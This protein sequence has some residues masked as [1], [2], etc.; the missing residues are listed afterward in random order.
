MEDDLIIFTSNDDD[1]R[2]A[3]LQQRGLRIEVVPDEANQL[4]ARAVL[5]RIGG[6]GLISVLTEAGSRLNASLLNAQITDK[7]AVF[8]APVI[9]GGDAVPSFAAGIASETMR[10]TRTHIERFNN[11]VLFTGYLHDPWAALRGGTPSSPA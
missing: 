5:S 1:K 7:V 11:D 8:T 6:L 9:L 10:F 3:Q 2:I 4:S